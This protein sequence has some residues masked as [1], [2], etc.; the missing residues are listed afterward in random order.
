MVGNSGPPRAEGRQGVFDSKHK[1]FTQMGPRKM[2]YIE[3][4]ALG[5]RN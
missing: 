2:F 4:I 5:G 3:I 1:C